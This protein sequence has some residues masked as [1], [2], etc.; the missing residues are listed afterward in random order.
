[1]QKKLL[2][3]ATHDTK[4][5]YNPHND[6]RN[7]LIQYLDKLIPYLNQSHLVVAVSGGADSMALCLLLN[8]WIKNK[9]FKLTAITVDHQLRPDS[10]KEANQVH[11]WLS[12][13]GIHHETLVWS[14]APISTNIQEHAREAR[15][16]LLIDYCKTH[17]IQTLFLAHH[18]HDQWETFLMRLTHGSGLKGLGAM[19]PMVTRQEINV[20]RPFLTVHPQQLKDY[21]LEKNQG[22]IE[23][24]SNTLETYERIRWRKQLTEL[25]K[26]GLTPQIISKG[27]E[28]LHA[29]NE[30]L[31]WC[32][33][34]WVQDNTVFNPQLKFIIS[35]IKLIHVPTALM[36]RIAL[37]IV[38]KVRGIN[39]TSQDVRHNMDALYQKLLASPF[40]AFTFG[41]CYWMK[42]QE[43]L[44]VMREWDKCP[45]DVISS[46][47]H[48]YDHRFSLTNLPCGE[49]L[50]SIGKKH[51]PQVKS[52]FQSFCLPYQIFL[53]LPIILKNKKVIWWLG[54]EP[55]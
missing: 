9:H 55:E 35:S 39:I 19:L 52:S 47:S 26:A 46:A 34:N 48:I 4:Y 23:D 10:S 6:M 33:T 18:L 8:D 51:W 11:Q 38:S 3:L 40:K 7:L 42:Y 43:N 13:Y 44:Y 21:L 49:T 22:W 50:T 29:E 20:F 12:N 24:P 53:S 16:K 25:S 15:Y 2:E 32:V 31:D 30:A 28:K 17:H 54:K 5:M 41:G 36:K 14:H 27:C 45:T 37:R 1:L